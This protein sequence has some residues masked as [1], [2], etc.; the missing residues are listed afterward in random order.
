MILKV[1][2][3]LLSHPPYGLGRTLLGNIAL[4][5]V[6]T[7]LTVNLQIQG[8]VAEGAAS[9]DA[10]GAACAQVLVDGI[11]KIR[12]LDELAVDGASGA[13]HVLCCGVQVPDIGPVVTT[14]EVTVSTDNIRMHTLDRGDRQHALCLAAATMVA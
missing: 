12:I 11:L 2:G 4:I 9:L 10:L 6:D 8:A 1:I 13:H 5:A 3:V 7:E 14:A